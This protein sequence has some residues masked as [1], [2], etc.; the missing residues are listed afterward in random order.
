MS[1]NRR[2][3]SVRFFLVRMKV[4]MRF[5]LANWRDKTSIRTLRA[6]PARQP[7]HRHEK[8][9][10]RRCRKRRVVVTCTSLVEEDSRRQYY[11]FS[12]LLS[13]ITVCCCIVR[14]ACTYIAAVAAIV[15]VVLRQSSTRRS[16]CWQAFSKRS[17]TF[18]KKS[19][20]SLSGR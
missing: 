6:N 16:A 17:F 12:L 2:H 11:N 7:T 8:K 15:V 10:L 18:I 4:A 20:I 5:C 19:F 1:W 3:H 9:I 14:Q 13:L